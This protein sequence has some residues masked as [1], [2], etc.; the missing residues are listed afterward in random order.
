MIST[1]IEGL[2]PNLIVQAT[3]N[4]IAS[5]AMFITNFGDTEA[6]V[7]VFVCPAGKQP[8]TYDANGSLVSGDESCW[9]LKD[10]RINQGDTFI[11]NMEKF[12]LHPGD[13]IYV[14]KQDE[15]MKVSVII[16]YEEY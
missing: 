11:L 16:S 1:L 2:D 10:L 6:Y 15:N 5:I 14:Q 4:N 7:N 8:P 3:E 9:L 13:A 12:L